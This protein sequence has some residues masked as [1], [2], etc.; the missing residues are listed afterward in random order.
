MQK[1][2]LKEFL[3]ELW[4]WFVALVATLFIVGALLGGFGIVV[5]GFLRW[6]N[7]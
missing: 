7:G 5:F 1:T 6:I 4:M 3:K 2:S